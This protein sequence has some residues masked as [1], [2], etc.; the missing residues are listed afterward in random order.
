M[1]QFLVRATLAFAL[2]WMLVGCGGGGS[3]GT[4]AV[5]TS[6]SQTA[7][8]GPSQN[9]VNTPP[10]SPAQVQMQLFVTDIGQGTLTALPAWTS[11]SGSSL[12]AQKNLAISNLRDPLAYDSSHDLLYA[13][14]AASVLVYAQASALTETATPAR[15]ITL[16][17]D[18]LWGNAMVLDG[19][20]DTLYVAGSRRYDDQVLVVPQASGASGPV[21]PAR[22]LTINDGAHGIALDPGRATLYV[23]GSTT[24]VHVFPNI[25]SASGTVFAAR[26]LLLPIAVT[27]IAIDPGRD[28]LYAAD[29]SGGVTIVNGASAAS[30]VTVGTVALPNARVV[31]V[32]AAQDRLYVGA[33]DKAYVLG[34]A[35]TLAAGTS[36]PGAALVGASGS[37]VGGFA[38]P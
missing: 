9:A 25:D 4:S 23:I 20:H 6:S 21:V 16:P 35:S 34:H 33:Y 3:G 12:S 2:L 28:R 29:P 31:A 27:G 8:P 37:S 15:T 30:P 13:M 22:V 7:D 11:N 38:F 32:D 24:G 17:S 19:A 36:V 14:S 10:A 5:G 26:H 18:W 1:K